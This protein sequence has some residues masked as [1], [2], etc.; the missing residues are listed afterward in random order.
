MRTTTYEQDFY[1]WTRAQAAA[2]RAARPNR[3]DWQHIT[4]ELE[5]TGRGERDRMESRIRQILLHLLKWQFQPWLRSRS[6]RSTLWVQRRDLAK[7]L[8]RNPS[9]CGHVEEALA[10]E[11]PAALA[12]ALDETGLVPDT[13]S[14]L[15]KRSLPAV[16][17]PPDGAHRS[18]WLASYS[19]LFRRV[20]LL[21]QSFAISH[22]PR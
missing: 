17:T 21:S 4:E 18:S 3:F 12:G 9:L 7:L 11:Y 8:R 19:L 5:A 6:W 1:A 22:A 20:T 2:L 10:E 13:F 16:A 14:H 15:R